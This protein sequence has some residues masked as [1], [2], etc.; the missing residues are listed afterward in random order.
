M[1]RIDGWER[2]DG[3]TSPSSTTGWVIEVRKT[4]VTGE[5]IAPETLTWTLR[6]D[7]GSWEQVEVYVRD[8]TAAEF[9]HGL[10]PDCAHKLYP[11]VFDNLSED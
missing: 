8:R 10:C 7:E 4:E 6:D 3:Q 9:S 1:T 2:F 5:F 11:E